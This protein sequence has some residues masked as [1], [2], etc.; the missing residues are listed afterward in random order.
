MKIKNFLR[1]YHDL[2]QTVAS[3]LIPNPIPPYTYTLSWDI[4]D[5]SFWITMLHH[6]Q[7]IWIY[8]S[9]F[10][11][12]KST[13]TY[14]YPHAKN[15]LHI[16]THYWDAAGLS[17][18]CNLVISN[19]VRPCLFSMYVWISKSMYFLY[20]CLSTYKKSTSYVNSFQEHCNLIGQR[21]FAPSHEQEFC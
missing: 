10:M 14:I 17:F 3:K 16:S 6:A 9:N 18:S 1:R 11:S 13:L 20:E 7:L 8:K 19:Y 12:N 15:Q 21:Y 4:V 2:I 5:L